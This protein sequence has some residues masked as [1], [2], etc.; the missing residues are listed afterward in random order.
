[1]IYAW[2]LYRWQFVRDTWNI[3]FS[4]SASA[5]VVPGELCVC[6]VMLWFYFLP[7]S[8]APSPHLPPRMQLLFC[9][10]CV[11]NCTKM[12]FLDSGCTN[13]LHARLQTCYYLDTHCTS[14]LC[15][16]YY[17]KPS[18][19]FYLQ[20]LLLVGCYV[21]MSPGSSLLGPISLMNTSSLQMNTGSLKI[22]VCA[23]RTFL[24]MYLDGRYKRLKW[25]PGW[26]LL[27]SRSLVV[28]RI[29]TAT[30]PR[31]EEPF[32]YGCL[33]FHRVETPGRT[34]DA[35]KRQGGQGKGS[36]GFSAQAAALHDPMERS[37]GQQVSI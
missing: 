22:M 30:L 31:W 4:F 15:S 3:I 11:T 7:P 16:V 6:D 5:L 27:P 9:G 14:S 25:L 2:N 10:T 13:M 34:W 35:L 24:H 8:P 12:S 37:E 17:S 18:I 29:G 1:M 33:M 32:D 23:H 36:L 21:Q 20:A 19:L 26:A 28:A